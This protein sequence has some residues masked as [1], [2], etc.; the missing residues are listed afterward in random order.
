[1]CNSGE[2]GDSDL[3][4]QMLPREE[5]QVEMQ[6]EMVWNQATSGDL[7]LRCQDR[8]A[9]Q[10]TASVSPSRLHTRWMRL[11]SDIAFDMRPRCQTLSE[12]SQ[13]L[14]VIMRTV[15][16]L[17]SLPTTSGPEAVVCHWGTFV[18]YLF[19]HNPMSVFSCQSM[20]DRWNESEAKGGERA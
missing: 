7:M 1:M 20:G 16:R 2:S 12:E 19:K 4:W 3:K 13:D 6:V 8:H 5:R 10:M 17:S 15:D 11:T 9:Q 14:E 18:C